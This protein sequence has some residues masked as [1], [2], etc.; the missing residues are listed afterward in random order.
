MEIYVNPLC[1]ELE[2]I[3]A[4]N[5]KLILNLQGNHFFNFGYKKDE[6]VIEVLRNRTERI[7]RQNNSNNKFG[8]IN[9]LK[10]AQKYLLVTHDTKYI[11]LKLKSSTSV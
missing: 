8:L 10:S 3:K 6:D 5:R 11:K 7:Q 4:E 1:L 2:K 9:K